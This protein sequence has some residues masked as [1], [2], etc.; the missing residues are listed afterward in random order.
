MDADSSRI[1][2]MMDNVNPIT[3]DD[4]IILQRH[5]MQEM[6]IIIPDDPGVIHRLLEDLPELPDDIVATSLD[7]FPSLQ[8]PDSC[9]P[10]TISPT[11]VTSPVHTAINVTSSGSSSTANDDPPNPTIGSPPT[12]SLVRVDDDDDDV[13]FGSPANTSLP[14]VSSRVNKKATDHVRSSTRMKKRFCCNPS[15]K[16]KKSRTELLVKELASEGEVQVEAKEV[17]RASQAEHIKRERQR[18]DEMAAKYTHLETL[19][20]PAP[21]VNIIIILQ[22][23]DEA[24]SLSLLLFCC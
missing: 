24:A 9:T 12:I 19:L 14:I 20:P 1:Q 4:E 11:D 22:I 5:H 23:C 18:R 6:G 15:P 10:T 16:A 13:D 17:R 7:L 3:L 2:V 21:K 8:P